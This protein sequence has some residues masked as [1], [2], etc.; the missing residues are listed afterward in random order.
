MLLKFYRFKLA[1]LES[2]VNIIGTLTSNWFLQKTLTIKFNYYINLQNDKQMA[3]YTFSPLEFRSLPHLY[4]IH[5][6]KSLWD[7]GFFWK[8]NSFNSE[9]CSVWVFLVVLIEIF[10]H[11]ILFYIWL[12]FHCYF[13]TLNHKRQ[14]LN[15]A[16]EFCH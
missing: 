3:S 12:S 16:K 6:L 15:S 9:K 7:H 14:I 10:S 13:F 2:S 1:T 11:L 8:V 5:F 4:T